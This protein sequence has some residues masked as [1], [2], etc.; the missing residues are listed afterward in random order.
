MT[1]AIESALG[2]QEQDS[3]DRFEVV[4]CEEGG[5]CCCLW[6]AAIMRELVEGS[7]VMQK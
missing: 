7:G 4:E 2:E 3:S 6:T 5:G 1:T